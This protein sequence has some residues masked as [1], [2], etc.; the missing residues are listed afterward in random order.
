MPSIV[1]LLTKEGVVMSSYSTA[2]TSRWT[3][4]RTPAGFA[5]GPQSNTYSEILTK[6]LGG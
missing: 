2:H 5:S 1:F 6:S 4:K 3:G